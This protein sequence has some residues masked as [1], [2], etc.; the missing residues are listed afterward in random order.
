MGGV[1]ELEEMAIAC[2]RLTSFDGLLKGAVE[3]GGGDP[4]ACLG[5]DVTDGFEEAVEVDAR[6][7][8]SEDHRGV[9]EEEQGFLD[10]TA[11]VGK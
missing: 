9:I 10:P 2:D 5:G 8:G 3:E 11:E 7:G 4:L 1:E 6:G